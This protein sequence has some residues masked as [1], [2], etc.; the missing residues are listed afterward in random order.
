ME[1]VICKAGNMYEGKVLVTLEKNN[2]IILLKE[3]PGYK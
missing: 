2:S 1:W 3:V